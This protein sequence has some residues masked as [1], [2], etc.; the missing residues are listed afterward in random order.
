MPDSAI[1]KALTRLTRVK[2]DDH[3]VVTC[4]L[5]LEPRDRSRGKYLIKVK[6]R[7]KAVEAAL[8]E[9]ALPRGVH[10]EVVADLGRIVEFLK[11]PARLP[12]T[13]GVAVF[14][15]GP[16]RLFETL[17]L[18]R[19][20]R[21]RLAVDR[22]PL[23]RELAAV[24]DEFG[25]LLVV[26]I[27]RTAA[28]F[29][30]VTAF[31]AEE[32]PGLKAATT[33]GGRFHSERKNSPGLGEFAYHN[34]IRSER[35]RHFEAVA[36]RL[37]ELNRRHPVHG[38]VLAG[39]GAEAGAVEPFL[40]PYLAERLMG[41]VAL[42]PKEVTPPLVHQAAL[43]VREAFERA[44]EREIAHELGEALGGGWAVSGVD[45]TLR[46]LAKGQV[47]TLLVDADAAMPGFR[48]AASGRLVRHAVDLR[49]EGEAVP[50]LDLID[51]AIEDA[52]RQRVAVEV[53]YDEAARPALDGLAG[54]L[55]FR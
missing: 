41:T 39:P 54:L 24:E 25:T 51:E 34:R 46:A 43:A 37:F 45:A 33:R 14:A 29:F 17:A 4:Y 48:A 12:R 8:D 31:G 53:I 28:R 21:S 11:E 27:D 30:S 55:R 9:L 20:H 18:P 23:V 42:N 3:R 2:T 10:D 47:R 1:A 7:V 15:C 35:Q 40:H 13:Q 44:S 22:T 26:V 36:H 19:V 50:V 49:G 32:L 38:L 52:L 5:K 6:N 16:L